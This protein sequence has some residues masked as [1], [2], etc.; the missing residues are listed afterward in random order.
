MA[1]SPL[2]QYSGRNNPHPQPPRYMQFRVIAVSD[3]HKPLIRTLM[4]ELIYAHPEEL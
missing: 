4:F 3:I 2:L 1:S